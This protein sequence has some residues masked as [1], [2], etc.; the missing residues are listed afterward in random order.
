MRQRRIQKKVYGVILVA[1]AT[2]AI[3]ATRVEA[4]CVL[5]Q[6][7]VKDVRGVVITD[8]EQT[9]SERGVP[10]VTIRLVQGRGARERIVAES[11]T[12]LEGRFDLG[13]IR[14]GI[15]EIWG[16]LEGLVPA[17]G[18]L[19]VRRWAPRQPGTLYLVLLQYDRGDECGGWIELRK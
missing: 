16:E 9:G 13:K 12:D 2:A 14:P 11:V 3:L 19:R 15:Y 7:T 5:P 6:V 8:S 4:V 18:P 10:G 17:V 1:A